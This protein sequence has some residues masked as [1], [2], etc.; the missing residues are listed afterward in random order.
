M[1]EILLLTGAEGIGKSMLA[2]ALVRDYDFVE[3][4]FA[5]GV[6]KALI[7]LYADMREMMQSQGVELPALTMEMTYDRTAKE[8][9]LR[10]GL[11]LGDKQVSPRVLLQWFGT[12]IMRRHVSDDIWAHALVDELRA[13]VEKGRTK[14]VISDLR[15]ANELAAVRALYP[16][17]RVIR[18]EHYSEA[19]RLQLRAAALEGHV[20]MHGWMKMPADVVVYNDFTAIG[21][22]RMI[23][24]CVAS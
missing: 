12:E 7:P 14:F 3:L 2:H 15:F 5:A 18:I 19:S 13:H 8:T 22:K 4:T 1:V 23:D 17:A 10:E 24:Q 20:S 11:T 16:M 21:L 9:P 6:R